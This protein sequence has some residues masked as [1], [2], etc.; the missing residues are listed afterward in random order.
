MSEV[1]CRVRYWVLAQFVIPAKAGIQIILFCSIMDAHFRGH[2]NFLLKLSHYSILH[3][4]KL[5]HTFA[6]KNMAGKSLKVF[7]RVF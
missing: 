6:T 1:R 2:D 7:V 3:F 5:I 4:D